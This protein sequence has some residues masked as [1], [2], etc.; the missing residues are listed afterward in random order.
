VSVEIRGAGAPD[1]ET[2]VALRIRFVSAVR[3]VSEDSWDAD[4]RAATRGFFERALGDGTYVTWLA[5]V[6]GEPA[7]CVGVA[8]TPVP[9][10]TADLRTWDGLVLTMWVEPAFRRRGIGEALLA[11]LVEARDELGIRRLVL[12]ATEMGRPLYER[13]GFAPNPDWMELA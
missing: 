9:P 13:F 12:H 1:I 7:G 4:F 6:E 10:R 11:R 5:F 2:L 8:L 3:G